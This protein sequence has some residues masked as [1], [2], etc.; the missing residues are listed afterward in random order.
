MEQQLD[1]SVLLTELP[2]GAPS[3]VLASV[4]VQCDGLGMGWAG[5]PLLDPLARQERDELRWYLSEYWKWPYLGFAARGKRIESL[6][7]RVG[8]RLYE[9]VFRHDE[10]GDIVRA[11]QDSPVEQRQ[12]SIISS[13]P[14]VLALPWELLHDGDGF[15]AVRAPVALV[16]RLHLHEHARASRTFAPPLRILF[17]AARPRGAGFVDPR[18]LAHELLDEVQESINAGIIELEFLRPSTLAAL[19]ARLQQNERPIHVLHFDGHGVFNEQDRQGALAFEDDRGALHLVNAA[20]LAKVL[21]HSGVQLV[22]LTACHSARGAADDA[23]STV[24]ARLLSGGIDAVVAMSAA[25]LATSAARY[26]EAFYHAIASGLAIPQAQEQARAR[27]Y[28]D[29]RRHPLYRRKNEE[30][31]AVELQDWWVPHFYQQRPLHKQATHIQRIEEHLHHISQGRALSQ[32]M[33]ASPRYG[34]IGRARELLRLEHW[35]LGKKLVIISGFGG[36]GKTAL[37]REAAEWFTRTGLYTRACFVSFEHGGDTSKLLSALGQF[38]GVYDGFYRPDDAP[39][40]LARLQPVLSQ[41]RTLVI[42]DNLESILPGGEAPLNSAARTDLWD[43][44]LE[45]ANLGAGVLLTSRDTTFADKRLVRSRKVAHLA[46]KGLHREDAY[47]LASRLLDTLGIDRR[48]VPYTPLCELLARLDHHPLAIQLVLPTLRNHP[49][50]EITADFV[51]LLPTFVD[52]HATGRN[53]SLLASLEYSLRRLN[54]EQQALL[55]RLAVFEGGASEDEIREITCIPDNDWIAL[56]SALEQAALVTVEQ[57]HEFY[58]VPF[59]HFHP[60]LTPFLRGQAGAEDRALRERYIQRY[61]DFAEFLQAEDTRHPLPI[62]AITQRELPNLRRVFI[63]L[64]E[65]RHLDA[66]SK[67]ADRIVYHLNHFGLKQERDELRRQL[68]E[69][70]DAT[71]TQ[72]V[73]ALTLAEYLSASGQGEDEWREGNTEAASTRFEALLK[74]I[75]VRPAGRPLGRGSFEHGLTLGRLA[76][77]LREQG[78]LAIAEGRLREALAVFD[79]LIAQQPDNRN[80]QDRRSVL[81]T[82]LGEVL[83]TQGKYEQAR[84]VYEA[85]LKIAEQ[86][87]NQRQQAI[88]LMQ[89]A[90]LALKEQEDYAEARSRY[91]M[92]LQVTQALG[93]PELEASVWYELGTLALKQEAWN[94]AEQ[95]YRRSLILRERLPDVLGSAATCNTLALLAT[96]RGHPAEAEGW[97][98]HALELDAQLPPDRPEHAFH[99]HNLAALLLQEVEAGRAPPARLVEARDYAKRAF[100]I[101]EKQGA[102]AEIWST[103]YLLANIAELGGEAQVARDYRR[104]ASETYAA[105]EGNRSYVDRKFGTI[106]AAAASAA[107]GDIEAKEALESL[108][109]SPGEESPA[110]ATAIRRIWAGERDRHALTED[111]HALDALVVL[112][113]LETI[114]QS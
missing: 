38:L 48:Q 6:L 80:C 49:L 18:L 83:L 79:T 96:H 26:T 41:Q 8:Q 113:V 69:A 92:A 58:R 45:L 109:S 33:P 29:P 108:L 87:P 44:L 110:F 3:D 105:F 37:T 30:G 12:L 5:G 71:S 57:V 46:L 7:P 88:V 4:T 82:D 2:Q 68:S 102:S 91:T 27:L 1:L 106:I 23:L 76:R 72:T 56:R 34:F 19:N 104:K 35:L 42:T 67:L 11:W 53:R 50:A 114:A 31:A 13:L 81:L 22:V 16:R 60:V 43:A 78:Q 62:R 47:G 107:L 84:Q 52:D 15:L 64:L 66:A 10:A 100:A 39:A 95:Y 9:A 51:K 24:A 28:A 36:I 93:E 32:E 98:V 101:D 111:L 74:R 17:I 103:L 59:I 77:C 14:R 25:F 63:L 97:Y 99:L 94:E 40:A 55:R 70:T 89:L 86:Q 54:E 112:R 90:T 65:A 75:E 85:A 21:R 61:L 73:E 20:E